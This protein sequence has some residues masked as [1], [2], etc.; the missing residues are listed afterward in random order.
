MATVLIL[1]QFSDDD[2]LDDLEKSLFRRCAAV[3]LNIGES[4]DGIGV[5]GV[6]LIGVVLGGVVLGGVVLGGVVL[7]GVVLVG[8]VLVGEFTSASVGVVLRW[9]STLRLCCIA[10]LRSSSYGRIMSVSLTSSSFLKSCS[11]DRLKLSAVE[12]L[13]L[14]KLL[15][16]ILCSPV[17]LK[18]SRLSFV[19]LVPC[20]SKMTFLASFR[21]LCICRTSSLDSF[22][23]PKVSVS[24]SKNVTE[25]F[26]P[27]G[28]C[29]RVML[30]VLLRLGWSFTDRRLNDTLK[31][32]S[33]FFLT[34]CGQGGAIS[35]LRRRCVPM[36]KM[37]RSSLVM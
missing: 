21:A 22:K 36:S 11:R 31:L 28:R 13:R 23:L 6:V 17:A 10:R 24:S 27:S 4:V 15:E 12:A 7:V 5:T 29:V 14:S 35:C 8:V 26:L 33:F 34:C 16:A 9:V 30:P 18:A 20:R 2:T 1:L 32:T 19:V 3:G 25:F 37:S